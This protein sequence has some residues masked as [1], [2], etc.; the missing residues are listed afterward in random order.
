MKCAMYSSIVESYNHR[1][2]ESRHAQHSERGR[3][4]KKLLYRPRTARSFARVRRDTAYSNRNPTPRRGNDN[5]ER[6][7]SSMLQRPTQ[8]RIPD[9]DRSGF[10]RRTGKVGRRLCVRRRGRY[11]GCPAGPACVR[12]TSTY[13]GSHTK[14]K[15]GGK[16]PTA[17]NASRERP[18]ARRGGWGSG[19]TEV[20][21]ADVQ[22]STTFRLFGPHGSLAPCALSP[23]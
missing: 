20:T 22:T 7:P 6:P 9:F 16:A 18:H 2:V 3:A 4:S 15:G 17:P 14:P 12:S 10:G 13:R 23:Y 8:R 5:E 19:E 21:G 11:G 1:Y